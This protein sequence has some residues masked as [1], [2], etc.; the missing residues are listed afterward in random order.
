MGFALNFMTSENEVIYRLVPSSTRLPF[1]KSLG[2][3]YPSS[4]LH[5]IFLP[6]EIKPCD[7]IIT[8]VTQKE[9]FIEIKQVFHRAY[10]TNRYIRIFLKCWSFGPDLRI[11]LKCWS[12]GPELFSGQNPLPPGES[13]TADINVDMHAYCLQQHSTWDLHPSKPRTIEPWMSNN[14]FFSQLKQTLLQVPFLLPSL[15]MYI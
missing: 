15:H 9:I 13:S 7:K 6:S 10:D 12:F 11:V 8:Q 5:I 4:Y 3:L 14:T 1:I 2:N